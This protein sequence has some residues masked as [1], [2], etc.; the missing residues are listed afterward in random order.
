MI[1][2]HI[3]IQSTFIQL[4]NWY[5]HNFSSIKYIYANWQVHLSITSQILIIYLKFTHTSSL[6]LYSKFIFKFKQ[7]VP[8]S[9]EKNPRRLIHCILMAADLFSPNL[10]PNAH[11]SLKS[12]QLSLIKSTTWRC[13]IFQNLSSKRQMVWKLW[14]F[15]LVHRI[16]LAPTTLQLITYY[17]CY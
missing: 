9:S 6:I 8:N 12:S 3:S 1:K 11:L 15:K 16:L 17:N 4:C 2:V 10:V 14:K 13:T 7:Q 5:H